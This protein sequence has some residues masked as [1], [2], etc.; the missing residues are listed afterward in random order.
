MASVRV[1]LRRRALLLLGALLS[2]PSAFAVEKW[3]E[4]GQKAC[5]SLKAN[6]TGS[7]ATAY[8]ASGTG[9]SATTQAMTDLTA[10]HKYM[11]ENGK[12]GVTAAGEGATALLASRNSIST[13]KKKAETSNVSQATVAGNADASNN[14][15]VAAGKFADC[16]AYHKAMQSAYVEIKDAANA[17][18][19]VAKASTKPTTQKDF[20][21]K[22]YES[23]L[24]TSEKHYASYVKEMTTKAPP[25]CDQA[26]KES[27]ITSGDS[28]ANANALNEQ[29][30]GTGQAQSTGAPGAAAKSVGT[31]SSG[32]N[33]LGA[34][35]ALGA[36]GL[37]GWSMSQEDE[38]QEEEDEEEEEEE[39]S[40][41]ESGSEE[42][43]SESEEEDTPTTTGCMAGYTLDAATQK[44]KQD[45]D[46]DDEDSDDDEEEDD[47][48]ADDKTPEAKAEE[49]GCA[50]NDIAFEKCYDDWK[51]GQ[52]STPPEEDP[53]EDIEGNGL[54]GPSS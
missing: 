22:D 7:S 53:D 9:T 54:N 5:A 41:T 43:S 49:S 20:W 21:I 17:C 35:A 29:V 27:L 31:N 30:N 39:S 38:P 16:D 40:G 23:Q 47:D 52:S 36:G 48:D 33:P 34:M 10:C 4:D 13:A 1:Y 42:T 3:A 51:N 8:C 45:E 50:V 32:I 18:L 19:V 37:L 28:A 6:S 25:S 26:I 12:R 46:D 24:S 44:C 14:G 11:N 2:S 15:R